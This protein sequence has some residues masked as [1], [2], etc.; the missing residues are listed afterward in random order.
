M[1]RP[2]EAAGEGDGR[3]DGA[4]C[5]CVCVYSTTHTQLTRRYSSTAVPGTHT[6]L[7]RVHTHTRVLARISGLLSMHVRFFNLFYVLQL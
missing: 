6:Q 7:T 5:V 3:P 2:D 4:V 1:D